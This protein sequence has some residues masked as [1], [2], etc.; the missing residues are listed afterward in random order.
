MG[1][2][3]DRVEAVSHVLCDVLDGGG[4]VQQESQ[5]GS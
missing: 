5:A 3:L 1:V 2:P 4:G